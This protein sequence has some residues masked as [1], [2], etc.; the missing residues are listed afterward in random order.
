MCVTRS[1]EEIRVFDMECEL[2]GL[3]GHLGVHFTCIVCNNI[4]DSEQIWISID[5]LKDYCIRCESLN[6]LCRKNGLGWFSGVYEYANSYFKVKI[7]FSVTRN[8]VSDLV[9]I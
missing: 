7:D 4:A 9:F 6:S 3:V 5:D 1:N 2:I 8:D